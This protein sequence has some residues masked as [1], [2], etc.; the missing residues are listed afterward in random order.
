MVSRVVE[1]SGAV[2][3]SPDPSIMSQ[4]GLFLPNNSNLS[5][6]CPSSFLLPVFEHGIE[7]P[8]PIVEDDFTGKVLPACVGA[9]G[10][11]RVRPLKRIFIEHDT[12]RNFDVCGKLDMLPVELLTNVLDDNLSFP[13]TLQLGLQANNATVRT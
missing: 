9:D 2:P 11:H 4:L 7:I 5:H 10:I 3:K 6:F 13:D 1:V 8:Q 12:A